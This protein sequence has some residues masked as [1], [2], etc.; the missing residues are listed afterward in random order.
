MHDILLYLYKRS[1]FVLVGSRD[2]NNNIY[3]N[4]GCNRVF[5]DS[6][7]YPSHKIHISMG[8]LLNEPVSENIVNRAQGRAHHDGGSGGLTPPPPNIIILLSTSL[9]TDTIC[10]RSKQK[11][12]TIFLL[13]LFCRI[14]NLRI[15]HHIIICNTISSA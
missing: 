14:P 8:I 11:K 5:S 2:D 3:Y 4:R 9:K 13:I 6:C 10:I 1:V 7:K 12:I 15:Y